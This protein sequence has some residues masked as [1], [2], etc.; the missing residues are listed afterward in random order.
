ME[1]GCRERVALGMLHRRTGEF[2]NPQRSVDS[3]AN[4]SS[5]IGR[6]GSTSLTR[7]LVQRSTLID[8]CREE[9]SCAPW[10]SNRLHGRELDQVMSRPR[11]LC[12]YS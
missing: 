7:T 1:W 4:P 12:N 9:C 11:R 8:T 3:L 10:N 6:F 2:R 5:V